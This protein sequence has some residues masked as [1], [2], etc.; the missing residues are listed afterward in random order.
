M[1]TQDRFVTC[2]SLTVYVKISAN[3]K[4]CHSNSAV[5]N[6]YVCVCATAAWPM[7]AIM[8]GHEGAWMSPAAELAASQSPEVLKRPL[9]Q[10][11]E[12]FLIRWACSF[13]D[14][15]TVQETQCSLTEITNTERK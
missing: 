7:T 10:H 15:L 11:H 1:G 13:G 8:R 14:Y 5:C 4:S 9:L 12:T 2:K 3:W 6:V